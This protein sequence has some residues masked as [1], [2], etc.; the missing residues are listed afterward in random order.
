[1]CNECD[2]FPDRV[3]DIPLQLP[4]RKVP[5]VV[6][7]PAIL[8]DSDLSDLGRRLSLVEFGCHIKE[9]HQQII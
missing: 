1:M 3:S 2:K 6:Y 4:F 8:N 5:L 9:E 7:D